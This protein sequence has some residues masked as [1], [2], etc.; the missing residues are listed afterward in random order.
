LRG[1]VDS[2]PDRYY[3]SVSGLGTLLVPRSIALVGATETSS[4]AQAVI[5]NLTDFGYEGAIHLVHPRHSEQFGRTCHPTL[6]AIPTDVDCAYVMT[7]TAAAAQVIEDCGRKRVPS[8]VMLSAGFKEVGAKGLELEQAI[9]ARC[10]ELDISLLGPNCLGFINYKDKVAAYGLVLAAPVRPGPIALISQSGVMLLHFHRLA[11]ARG[12]GLAAS[13]SIGNEA[14]LKASDLLEEFVRREDVRVV[15]ALLE[16]IRDP[17]GF[18][19]AAEAAFDAEKPLVVLK[20]GRSEVSRRVVIAHTGSLAGADAVVDAVLR[21]KGAIRVTSPEELIETCALLATSGWPRGGRTAVVTTS[22]GA[23]GL[24]SDLA[25]GTRVALPDFTPETKTR[26]ADLLPS[27]GTPQNPLDTT[28]VIVNQPALL[29]ACVDAVLVDGGFDAL[30]INSDPP[31]DVGA[32]PGR[33][34]ERLAPL[35]EMVRRAPIFTAVSATVSSEL[36]PF[37][38]ETLARYGLHFA[39]GLQLGIRA[40]DNAVFYGQARARW[41]RP[42]ASP[43]RRVHPLDRGWTGVIGE[44]Q[45]KVLLATY[46]IGV[47]DERLVHSAG[48]A[49]AAAASIG[50][51]V[52]VKVQSRDIAHKTEVGGVKLGLRTAA[53]VRRAFAEVKA[54]AREARFEGA[55]VSHQV[56]PVAELL[57]GISSDPQ[58]GHMVLVGM[59]GILTESLRDFSLRMPP[60][61]ERIGAEMLEELRGVAVLRGER[62]RPP[63]DLSALVNVLVALGDI[64][65]DL[66]ERLVE[67]DINPL[68]ALPEGAL[69]GDALLVV[70]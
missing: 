10:R 42:T 63:A 50:Y 21:Q 54:V 59:G 41:T 14:M 68:F 24:V 20:V 22:G 31:R 66:G 70:R 26:L 33:V 47:P 19:A 25:C 27:F 37:G 35:A 34:E 56:E 17:E 28:G 69:A 30:L 52:V 1:R 38:M 6:N 46:G 5:S 3:S 60:I 32:G 62:G 49:V 7:G 44:V 8:V 39:N 48:D 61:D 15:G 12:I 45:A 40:L 13:V 58:F 57:A 53:E 36:T 11:M 65:L 16:G 23:C 67:L 18:V 9:V 2:A 64:A 29:A 55:L 51:P 43:A 4:W